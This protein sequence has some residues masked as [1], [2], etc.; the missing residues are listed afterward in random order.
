[1]RTI[2]ITDQEI[3]TTELAN[4][5]SSFNIAKVEELLSEKGE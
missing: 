2:I 3:I 5:S 4:A 1:M